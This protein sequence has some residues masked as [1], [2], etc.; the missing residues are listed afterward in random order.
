MSFPTTISLQ[1]PR[2]RGAL[3]TP[4]CL[5]AD[6]RRRCGAAGCQ[7][8]RSQIN[9]GVSKT[10]YPVHAIARAASR[11]KQDPMMSYSWMGQTEPSRLEEPREPP[12][13]HLVR[14][15]RGGIAGHGLDQQPHAIKPRCPM[16]ILGTPPCASAWLACC[17]FGGHRDKVVQRAA[18]G[19]RCKA[20]VQ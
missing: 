6:R 2:S 1:S 4:A 18:G 10:S 11:T 19:L 12:L 14:L 16:L 20:Q 8:S 13:A 7:P 3:G 15:D 9:Y 17:R 5:R